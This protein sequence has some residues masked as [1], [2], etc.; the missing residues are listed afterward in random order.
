M[1][2][3]VASN[4]SKREPSSKLCLNDD[5]RSVADIDALDIRPRTVRVYALR[6]VDPNGRQVHPRGATETIFK[7][8]PKLWD[9]QHHRDRASRRHLAIEGEPAKFGKSPE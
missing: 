3:E 1:I 2:A 7:C 8:R 9:L 6:Q 5:E 4:L